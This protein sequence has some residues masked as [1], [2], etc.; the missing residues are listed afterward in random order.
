[1]FLLKQPKLYDLHYPAES[2]S[3]CKQLAFSSRGKLQSQY[4]FNFFRFIY[5]KFHSII[6]CPFCQPIKTIYFSFGKPE[7]HIQLNLALVSFL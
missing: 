6:F 1:M 4:A 2:Y 5:F 3:V 7:V